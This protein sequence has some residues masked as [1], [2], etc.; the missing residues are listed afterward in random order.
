[1]PSNTLAV[2]VKSSKGVSSIVTVIT[3]MACVEKGSRTPSYDQCKGSVEDVTVQWREG[4]RDREISGMVLWDWI[5]LGNIG[6]RECL[7]GMWVG[8]RWKDEKLEWF[9]EMRA[10]GLGA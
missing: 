8:E 6:E 10:W 4:L 5:G 2:G 3:S 7:K 1:M 9:M